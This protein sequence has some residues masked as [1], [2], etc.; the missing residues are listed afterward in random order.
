[1]SDHLSTDRRRGGLI[2]PSWVLWTALL[3]ILGSSITMAGSAIWGSAHAVAQI[4]S[5]SRSVDDIRSDLTRYTD[6]I[7]AEMKA[8]V[9]ALDGKIEKNTEWI[10]E[11]QSD[12]RYGHKQ[13]KSGRGD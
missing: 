6:S 9:H 10:F 11:I 12:S 4:A 3:T 13:Q 7:Q 5:I 8:T 2:I 1:M